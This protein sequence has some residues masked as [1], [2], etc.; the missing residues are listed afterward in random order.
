MHHTAQ[1]DRLVNSELFN[2]D[3]RLY[4]HESFLSLI[5]VEG[6]TNRLPIAF[7]R[8]AFLRLVFVFQ[9]LEDYL[10]FAG[11]E[12]ALHLAVGVGGVLGELR[13]VFL[14]LYVYYLPLLYKLIIVFPVARHAL[15]SLVLTGNALARH[16]LARETM[17]RGQPVTTARRGW[18]V[19]IGSPIEWSANMLGKARWLYSDYLVCMVFFSN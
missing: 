10:V 3:H 8:G 4:I 14:L 13:G 9:M 5:G 1:A 11:E 12:H 16:D 17:G 15:T 18:L 7:E 19:T 2:L 6:T